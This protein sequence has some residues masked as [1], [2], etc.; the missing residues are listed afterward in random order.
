MPSARSFSFVLVCF[1][2][3]KN[4]QC[5]QFVPSFS[6]PLPEHCSPPTPPDGPHRRAQF[7]HRPHCQGLLDES[8]RRPTARLAVVGNFCLLR[9]AILLL[10]IKLKYFS[11]YFLNITK[12]YISCLCI[13]KCLVQSVL[14]HYQMKD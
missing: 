13:I 14:E 11:T 6:N 8:R 1:V 2:K 12:K 3:Q 10:L 5:P 9:Q 4:Q 7:H